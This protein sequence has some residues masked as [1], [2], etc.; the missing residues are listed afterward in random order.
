MI[1]KL[2]P[3]IPEALTNKRISRGGQTQRVERDGENF[4]AAELNR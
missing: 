4:V 3:V 1:Q 2:K